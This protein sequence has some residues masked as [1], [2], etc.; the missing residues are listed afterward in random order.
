[1]FKFIRIGKNMTTTLTSPFS[2]PKHPH[3]QHLHT[4]ITIL[5]YASY[6]FIPPHAPSY[7]LTLPHA[8]FT[9][10][11][12]PIHFPLLSYS[13]IPPHTPSYPSLIYP[14]LH[15]H[16]LPAIRS[17]PCSHFPSMLTSSF[18]TSH[19]L[20]THMLSTFILTSQ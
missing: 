17:Y 3:I 12:L 2:C 6:P 1:M 15:S 20:N 11:S 5:T 18:H 7:S 4:D 14:H 16:M 8:L 13:S 9:F 19:A 10:P